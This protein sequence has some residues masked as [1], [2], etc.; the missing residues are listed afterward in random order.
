VG[1]RHRTGTFA[2]LAVLAVACAPP[3]PDP[4]P[5]RDSAPSL[6][7]DDSAR[8]E[9]PDADG[10]GASDEVDCDD[11][12]A[13]VFPGAVERCDE[14]DDDCDGSVAEGFADFD[15]DGVPDCVDVFAAGDP[16]Q[17]PTL[18]TLRYIPAG[19]FTMGCVP[20]RDDVAGGCL[21]DESP[22][23]V[24]TITEGFWVMSSELTQAVWSRLGY[25][26]PSFTVD[27]RHPV[28]RATWWE[29][30]AFANAVSRGDGLTSCYQLTGC[31]GA[32]GEGMTCG[33]ATPIAGCT[34]W[35]LPTEAEWEW[36]ARAGTSYPYAA[37]DDGRVVGW[38]AENA[39]GTSQPTCRKPANAWGLCDATGNV[40]E[41][42]ADVHALYEPWAATDPSGPSE[43]PFRVFRGGHWSNDL[44]YARIAARLHNLPGVRHDRVGFRLV[45]AGPEPGSGAPS[46]P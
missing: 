44:Q 16:V 43:G 15:A 46:V 17:H 7:P 40:A 32:V 41:W 20:G 28:D 23:H 8:G 13:S 10:D 26:N 11:G 1:R 37:G 25:A 27:P 33:A 2:G 31:R 3:K 38:L 42:V 9:P 35:R 14:V 29:A 36:A 5:G 30:I 22:P 34:G 4:S 6:L 18:G 39:D 24:V 12:D 45:C 19:T 21:E